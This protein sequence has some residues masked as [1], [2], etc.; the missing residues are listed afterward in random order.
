M[1]ERDCFVGLAGKTYR[2]PPPLADGIGGRSGE[3]RNCKQPGANNAEGEDRL[4]EDPLLDDGV[5]LGAGSE[6]Q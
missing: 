5:S 2:P 1:P 3:N 6:T 4:L